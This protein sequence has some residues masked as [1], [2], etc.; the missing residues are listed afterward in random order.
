[1]DADAHTEAAAPEAPSR[2]LRERVLRSA[3]G[4][5]DLGAYARRVGEMFDLPTARAEELLALA[6]RA[7]EAP[8]VS[9]PLPGLG[10]DAAR[11]LHFTGGARVAAH[12]CG[13]AHLAPGAR[14]PEHEHL[15][16][17]WV[18]VLAGS[19]EE[20]GSGAAWLPGDLVHWPAGSRHAFRATGDAALVFAVVLEVRIR[21]KPAPGA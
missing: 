20:E 16:D 21:L 2:S 15:G 18:L 14:F 7:Q 9:A 11:L 19:A 5:S 8:W 3:R 1:V 17:E 10:A 13:F 12:D 6:P 4:G